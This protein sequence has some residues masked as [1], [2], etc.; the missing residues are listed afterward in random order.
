MAYRPVSVLAL[1]V[2]VADLSAALPGG[3][4]VG[5]RV[6]RPAPPPLE[7]A[8]D[9]LAPSPEKAE[10]IRILDT[11]AFRG[12]PHYVNDHCL[13][14]DARGFWH[15]FGIFAEEPASAEG[16]RAFVHAISR[17]PLDPSDLA[18]LVLD[19]ADPPFAL[20]RDSAIGETH[21]WAPHVVRDGD[22]YL[23]FYQSGGPDN[24]RAAVRVAES[25]DLS[26]WRRLGA[27]PLFED[28]CVARDPML[29]RADDRWVMYYTRCDDRGARRSGVAY[30]T[31]TDLVRWSEP[32]M[33]LVAERSEPMFNSGYTESPFVFER[34]GYYYLSTTAY[35]VAWDATFLFRSRSPFAFPDRPRARLSAHAA[36]WIDDPRSG[37][38]YMTHAGPGQGGV[39]LSAVRGL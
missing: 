27:A 38:L 19:V 6:E 28:I 13:I 11:R 20:E 36:E 12:R 4:A 34:G 21:L 29:I 31:S 2:L 10:P 23:M 24:D 9:G 33:A 17:A 37:A 7:S 8:D 22:R 14:R 15:L 35:P 5:S 16:E 26:R 3:G 1:S 39:W 30:R 25:L 32:A 18:A